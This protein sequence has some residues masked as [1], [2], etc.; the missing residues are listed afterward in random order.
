MSP[1]DVKALDDEYMLEAYFPP[2]SPPL[3]YEIFVFLRTNHLHC[4]LSNGYGII[5]IDK[6]KL[7]SM[8]E[9]RGIEL[10]RYDQFVELFIER[11]LKWHRETQ[12]SPSD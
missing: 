1:E 6:D 12:S 5:G 10:V 7:E 9:R 4:I 2:V 8:A 3:S 11:A